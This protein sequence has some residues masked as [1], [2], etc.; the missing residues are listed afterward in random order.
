VRLEQ[1]QSQAEQSSHVFRSGSTGIAPTG[2]YEVPFSLKSS[3]KMGRDITR[4]FMLM[5]LVQI[6]SRFLKI[7]KKFC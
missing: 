4:H 6:A 7:I 2:I 3:E 5:W 1:T